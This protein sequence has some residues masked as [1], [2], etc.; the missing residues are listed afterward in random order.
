M[1]E[2]VTDA[3]GQTVWRGQ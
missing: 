2:R 1:P 3:D